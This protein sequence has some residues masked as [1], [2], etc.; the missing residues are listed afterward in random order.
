MKRESMIKKPALMTFLALLVV[1]SFLAACGGSGNESNTLDIDRPAP[2]AEYAGKSNPLAD[3]RNAIEAGEQLYASNC[4]ACHGVEAMGDGPA[5]NS[6][7]PKPKPLAIEMKMLQDDYLYWR[8]AEGGGFSPFAS[9]M[10]A[11]K[12][13]LSEEQ[14]WQVLAYLRTL[15]K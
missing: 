5:S 9:A 12:T 4:A 15:S 2:P 3:D 1:I 7:N 8:T 10:P 14:I 13:I 11:W 6:L